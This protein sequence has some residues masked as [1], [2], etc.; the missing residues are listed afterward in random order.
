MAR[1]ARVVVSG[2]PHH[3]TQRGNRQL[4]TLFNEDDYA[5]YP[6]SLA[7]GERYLLQPAEIRLVTEEEAK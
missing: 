2:V 7:M 5:T 1:L 3:V 6:A 4:E